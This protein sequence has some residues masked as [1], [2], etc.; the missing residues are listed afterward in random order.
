MIFLYLFRNTAENLCRVKIGSQ[1]PS[2]FLMVT[3]WSVVIAQQKSTEFACL[4]KD[5]GNKTTFLLIFNSDERRRFAH[6]A[7]STPL[8]LY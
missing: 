2:T 8:P 6:C 3:S 5:Y 1:G 7:E 4:V